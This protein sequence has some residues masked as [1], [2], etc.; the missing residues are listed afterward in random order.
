MSDHFA[1][2]LGMSKETLIQLSRETAFAWFKHASQKNVQKII[3]RCLT[4]CLSGF[5]MPNQPAPDKVML[6]VRVSRALKRRVQKAAKQNGVIVTDWIVATLTTQTQHITLTADD[7]R[8][9]AEETEEAARGIGA[10]K[11]LRSSRAG[12]GD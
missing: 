6:S 2:A 12:K 1:Q 3:V 7:Y 10:D 5:A 4:P 11:R 9:I 8:K